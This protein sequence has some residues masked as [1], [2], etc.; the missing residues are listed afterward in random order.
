MPSDDLLFS[1]E[2]AGFR[3]IP[4]VVHAQVGDTFWVDVV[5][6]DKNSDHFSN[7]N[8]VLNWGE[9]PGVWWEPGFQ[10]VWISVQDPNGAE[11]RDPPEIKLVGKTPSG[12]E[13]EL[14]V[15]VP[16][17]MGSASSSDWVG[18]DLPWPSDG[19][20]RRGRPVFALLDAQSDG[21]CNQDARYSFAWAGDLGE[22]LTGACDSDSD[23]AEVA[24]F[25]ALRESTLLEDPPFT[26]GTDEV[27]PT[28][29]NQKE[30]QLVF[31]D[32]AFREPG[33][34]RDKMED[35]LSYAQ[36]AFDRSAAGIVLVPDFRP[37]SD[38]TPT[39]NRLFKYT[40]SDCQGEARDS[41]L[42]LT[43][44]LVGDLTQPRI[45]V[46]YVDRL[47]VNEFGR[48][49]A[50]CFWNG[51]LPS[52]L[53]S[54]SL[55]VPGV[56]AHELGHVFGLNR[57]ALKEWS[58]HTE[59]AHGFDAT[60]LMRAHS[61][62]STGNRELFTLGQVYRMHF[63]SRS[64]LWSDSPLPSRCCQGSPYTNDP[65]PALW[66]AAWDVEDPM[67]SGKVTQKEADSFENQECPRGEEM[68]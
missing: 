48:A 52:V 36:T 53:I 40:D 67:S 58:G 51:R 6:L 2:V 54:A 49:G 57:D 23:G 47:S 61:A 19:R 56:L 44:F 30:V 8:P 27:I 26:A 50:F 35:D 55:D 20:T 68:P 43:E 64:W 28:L 63:D 62:G 59:N 41:L 31:W 42:A 1:T 18:A 21:G 24:L 3:L 38:T 66:V 5:P 25:S 34:L 17:T 32:W 10:G 29:S 39:R 4:P 33:D 11:T 60:N 9:T 16:S 15:L 13:A 65:C 45:H 12:I 37:I 22:D 7:K 14:R 46:I